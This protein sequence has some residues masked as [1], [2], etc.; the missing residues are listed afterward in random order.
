M[1]KYTFLE[2]ITYCITLDLSVIL[3]D[4][5]IKQYYFC[6]LREPVIPSLMIYVSS[7]LE[8]DVEI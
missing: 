2:V 5:P 6:I 1:S 3:I 8:A 4:S 7:N